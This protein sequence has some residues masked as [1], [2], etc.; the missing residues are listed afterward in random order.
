VERETFVR[1]RALQGLL[2]YAGLV[3]APNGHLYVSSVLTG[4][5]A[6]FDLDGRLVRMLLKSDDLLPP[7][8]TGTPYGLTVDGKGTLYYADLDLERS[9]LWFDAG[10]NGKVWRIRFANGEPLEPELVLD[11]LHFPD[12]LGIL[13]GDL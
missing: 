12:G 13:P 8:R 3:L 4:R 7:H 5:I 11:G 1:A 10:S 2:T 9:G 6:E